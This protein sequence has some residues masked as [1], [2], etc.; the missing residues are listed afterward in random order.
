MENRNRVHGQ[1][2][3]YPVA[4]L[5]RVEVEKEDYIAIVT[6]LKGQGVSN[7]FCSDKAVW[8]P[9]SCKEAIEAVESL[10]PVRVISACP[11]ARAA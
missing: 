2:W 4:P 11:A 8:L 7:I 9:A 5:V 1:T 6:F 10:F 3:S